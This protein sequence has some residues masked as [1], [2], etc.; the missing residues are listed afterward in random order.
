[1]TTYLGRSRSSLR[2]R[3]G[4][5]SLGS[6]QQRTARS[7]GP[8]PSAAVRAFLDSCFVRSDAVL[9]FRFPSIAS[10]RYIAHGNATPTRM[11]DLRDRLQAS[12]GESYRLDR[13]LERWRNVARVRR[14]RHT[15]R[16]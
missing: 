2:A 4:S 5:G 11:T 3:K 10:H 8:A 7:R 12:L 15:T 9:N 1:M 14:P 16:S 13:E 6:W